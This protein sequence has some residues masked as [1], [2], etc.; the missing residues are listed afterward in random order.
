MIRLSVARATLFAS[1]LPTEMPLLGFGS[2]VPLAAGGWSF[3]PF[4]YT[5]EGDRPMV[6]FSKDVEGSWLVVSIITITLGNNGT[7]VEGEE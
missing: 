7:L 1:V 6:R 5:Q 2:S 4:I 3:F